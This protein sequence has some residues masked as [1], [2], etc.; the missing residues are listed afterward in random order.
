MAFRERTDREETAKVG[1]AA[2]V[3]IGVGATAFALLEPRRGADRRRRTA[4][5][6]VHAGKALEQFGRKAVRDLQNRSRGLVTSMR[7]L[8]VRDDVTPEV[9]VER[10]RSHLGHLTSHPHA[11][12][13]G[14]RDGLIVLRGDVLDS[15]AGRLVE[16]VQAVPGVKEVEA[17]FRRHAHAGSIPRLQGGR[18]RPENMRG[19]WAPGTRFVAVT[20]GS[21]I[22]AASVKVGRLAGMGLG[23]AGALL[24]VR[25]ALNLP[26]RRLL[27]IGAERR[28]VDVRKAI[29]IDAPRREVFAYYRAFENFP[30]FMSHVHEVRRA[31]DGIWHWVVDGPVGMRFEWDAEVTET[32]P[33]E[34]IAW[35]TTPGGTV[36]SE[37]MAHFED[38]GSGTRL[39]IQ[40]SYNPPAGGIGHGVAMLLGVDPKRQMDDDLLRLKSLLER[41]R[42]RRVSLEELKGPRSPREPP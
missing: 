10:V 8:S 19:G 23:I 14:A 15:E 24:A 38:E 40:L 12:E 11:V 42:A 35:R 7:R 33:D 27:G 30:R 21:A 32:R 9:L 36:E 13:V 28:A 37:G 26:L 3:G 39:T 41:G 22:L 5:K 17:V 2:L 31:G 6:A 34:L 18:R 4:R 29:H 25:G 16:G 1:L 20:A